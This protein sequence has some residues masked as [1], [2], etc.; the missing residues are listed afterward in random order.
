MSFLKGEWKLVREA[1]KVLR[2]TQDT[3]SVWEETAGGGEGGWQASGKGKK[4][5]SEPRAQLF[6]GHSCACEPLGDPVPVNADS[7][8]LGWLHPHPSLECAWN[9]QVAESTRDLGLIPG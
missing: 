7:V 9:S 3:D 8:G 4:T 1:E 2:T 6:L 5:L